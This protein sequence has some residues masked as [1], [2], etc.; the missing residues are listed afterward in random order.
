MQW[1]P[2]PGAFSYVLDHSIE[3]ALTVIILGYLILSL[4]T[5]EAHKTL[6]YRIKN[7]SF[8]RALHNSATAI[9]LPSRCGRAGVEH[10]VKLK[11]SALKGTMIEEGMSNGFLLHRC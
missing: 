9:F 6:V 7:S 3:V 4:S 11:G 8:E 1:Q 2:Q 5:I 10:S